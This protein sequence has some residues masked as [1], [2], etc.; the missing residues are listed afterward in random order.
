VRRAVAAVAAAVLAWGSLPAEEAT[1]KKRPKVV[2][3]L[4]GGGARGAAHVGVIRVLEEYHVPVDMVIG[5]SMGSIVGGLY[6]SGWSIEEIEQKM[7]T[8][9]WSGVFVDTLPR[10]YRTFRRKTDDARFLIPIKMRFKNWKPYL[11]PAVLGGQSMELLFKGLEI[12]AT[13]ERD[14]DKFPIP[15]RAVASNFATGEC[16]VLDHGS[17]SDSMRA[18]MSLPGLF[19]PVEIDGHPLADGG[20]AANFPV[21]VAKGLGAEVV[22]G[23]DIS[24][25]LRT[26]AELGNILTRLD[27]VTGLLTNKNKAEDMAAVTDADVIMVPEL[28]EITA[29][30]FDRA[31]EAIAAGVEAARAQEARLRALSV[32]DEE[33]AAY[34]AR[35][36][37]R[38]ATGLVVDEV[39]IVN[40]GP[41]ADEIVARRIKVPI[42]EPLDQSK[43]AP[44][45][46]RL[47]SLDAFGPI[48]HNLI[49]GEDGK[50]VLT[51]E[52]P[53]KPYSRNSLQFGF[54]LEDNFQGDSAFNLSVSH[55]F[56]PINRR[57]G[58]WRNILQIGENE[59]ISSEFYQPLDIGMKW[60]VLPEVEFRRDRLRVYDDNGDALAEYRIRSQRARASVGRIFGNWGALA[61]GAFRTQDDGRLRIGSPVFPSGRV[62]DG[63]LYAT[64]QVDTLDRVTWPRDGSRAYVNYGRSLEALGADAEGNGCSIVAGK[65]A[66]IGKNI[67][68][69]SAEV[70]NNFEGNPSL[71]NVVLLGGFLRLSGLNNNELVGD[72]GGIARLLYYRELTSFS[73]GA[74]TQRM[75]AGL[76]LEAG[77]VYTGDEPVTWPSLRRAGSLY[78]G[79][80][81]VL[82]PVYLGFGYAEGNR[83]SVYLSIGQRF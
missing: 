4:S 13:G 56:N 28:G 24:T 81:T 45:L 76:S 6:A 66:T 59:L 11:P 57:G 54:N 43:L 65:A 48:K 27:Q 22:I 64:L 23:V 77:Q 12:D 68:F 35:Q 40:T 79:A 42:G 17:L 20:M 30:D 71:N 80:D 16:V 36:I 47:Y 25:P 7:T 10:Q 73:L 38:P 32:S 29:A 33:W 37:R 1:P 26:K 58:E 82:G 31:P 8:I 55:L 39:K 72:R 83:K 61:L 67:L 50:N 62:Q 74:L 53:P 15:Y 18:S 78:V 9:D 69:G 60:F 21:R 3:V 49:R 63:G 44:Q 70:Q 75:Y 14:F 52:T 34:K 19:P 41:L 46:L 51:I 2:L 5:T